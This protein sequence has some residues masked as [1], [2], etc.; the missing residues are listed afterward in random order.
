MLFTGKIVVRWIWTLIVPKGAMSSE[1]IASL[2]HFCAQ[3]S[4]LSAITHAHSSPVEL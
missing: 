2:G 4:T 3:V 1:D